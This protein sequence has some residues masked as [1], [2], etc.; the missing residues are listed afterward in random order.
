MIANLVLH[1]L[2]DDEQ[3]DALLADPGL[4]PNAVEE[5]LRLEPAAAVIDRYATRDVELGGV[6]IGR[7]DPVTLSIAAANRDPDLFVDP[8]RFDVH[9]PNANRH[10]TFAHGPHV[11]LGMHLARLE[12]QTALGRLL[13]RLPGVRLDPASPSAPRGLVFRKPPTLQV[14]WG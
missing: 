1:V 6:H 9:R 2:R 5:S 10:V 13:A 4:L 3:R 11:C 7:G 8:D 12:A 14:V